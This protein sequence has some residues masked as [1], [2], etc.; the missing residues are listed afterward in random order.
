MVVIKWSDAIKGSRDKVD[1]P[2][3]GGLYKEDHGSIINWSGTDP[4]A[5]TNSLTWSI[6][7]ND[8][9]VLGDKYNGVFN[10]WKVPINNGKFCQNNL[11]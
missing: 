6:E 9:I 4:D 2:Q 8:W 11:K 3:F 10:N 5:K 7:E 1:G